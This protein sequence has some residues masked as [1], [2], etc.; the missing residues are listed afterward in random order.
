MTTTMHSSSVHV[1]ATVGKVFDY[2]KDPAHFFDAM[3]A[4][5]YVEPGKITL[6]P[7]GI[8]TTYEWTGRELG[9]KIH[10]VLTRE[11]Y[12]PNERIV[13]RSSTGPVWTWTVAPEGDGTK[14]TLAY[15]YATRVP[16]MD[17]L[18]DKVAWNAERDLQT[19]VT[20]IKEKVEA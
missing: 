3:A 12:V 20:T 8:G 19:M 1:D 10:G 15:E 7:E 4:G 11:E 14:L 5:Q 9:F 13:D 16:L 2:V 17:K 6:T 18:I